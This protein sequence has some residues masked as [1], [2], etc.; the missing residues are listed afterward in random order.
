[1]SVEAVTTVGRDLDEGSNALSAPDPKG[2]DDKDPGPKLWELSGEPGAINLAPR[3][4][5]QRPASQRA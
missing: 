3:R 1:M 2:A 4:G 5:A